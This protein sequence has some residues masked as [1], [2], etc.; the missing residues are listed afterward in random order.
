MKRELKE[1]TGFLYNTL[2]HSNIMRYQPTFARKMTI[3]ASKTDTSKLRKN[4]KIENFDSIYNELPIYDKSNI[5]ND[6]LSYARDMKTY[7]S[8]NFINIDDLARRMRRY[9]IEWWKKYTMAV[10]CIIFFFIGA[11]LGAIIRKGGLGMP[12]VISVLFFVMWYIIS[13]SGE[14]LVREGMMPAFYGMWIS[15]II[16]LPTGIFLTRKAALDST[17]LN[18]DTYLNPVKKLVTKYLKIKFAKKEDQ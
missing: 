13:L 12:V 7:I 2:M 9:D 17:M 10:S 4:I 1:K 14:K 8:S 16:L 15:T 6:A 11:P 18:I 3:P 5:V